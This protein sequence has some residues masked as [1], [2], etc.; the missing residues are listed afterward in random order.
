MSHV[1]HRRKNPVAKNLNLN[2][3]V[4]HR[5][6]KNDYRRKAKYRD[7]YDLDRIM[8]DYRDL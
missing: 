1:N 5:D 7:H 3:A 6:R 2:R 8:K 4:T